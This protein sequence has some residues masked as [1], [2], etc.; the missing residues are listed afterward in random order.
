M[1]TIHYVGF[2][3][4]KKHVS[5][6]V[7]A[8]DGKIIAQG[9]VHSRREALEQWCQQQG[10]AWQ[11][12]M[13]ATLFSGWIY[14]A[15]K[16][17]AARLEMANPH[18][19]KAISAAKKKS[20]AIDAATLADLLRCNLLPSC[21]VAPPEIREM[22]RMLRYRTLVVQQSV[23][24]KNRISGLLMEVGVEYSKEKLHGKGYF[25][26]LVRGLKEV[27]A[28]VRQLLRYSR[29]AMEMFESTQKRLVQQLHKQRDLK[30]RVERLQSIPGVGEIT[31]LSWAL[32]V[33]EV[34]RFGSISQAWSYCGLTA[35]FRESADKQQ[36]GPISKQRNQ[37]L[38]TVLIEAAKL[39]PRWNPALAQLHQRELQRGHRNRATLAVA[40][41]LVAY[42]M[43]VDRSQQP[44]QMPASAGADK[45]ALVAS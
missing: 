24:M 35:A 41:K 36:R 37:H 11:G 23:R 25:T 31:A 12:A 44:F 2:D 39:A 26:E 38:Q 32:E 43:A 15:L 18:Q 29:A 8:A 1:D 6:C 5:Y 30:S 45:A 19:L 13:E 22:R 27:P 33:G 28:S 40:R 3:V 7:K 42:L 4:H 17:Y 16:P 9:R 20:D 21:Y 14:D 34:S 10:T